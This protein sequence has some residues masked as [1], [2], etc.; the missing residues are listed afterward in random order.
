MPYCQKASFKMTKNNSEAQSIICKVWPAC[1]TPEA[2]ETSGGCGDEDLNINE[3]LRGAYKEDGIKT[4]W[5]KPRSQLGGMTPR[6]MW[7][8]DRDKVW[9]LARSL[10]A[11]NGT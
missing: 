9:A 2:C 11:G 8:T 10:E 3:I 4:W 1:G 7:G 5:N 6:E